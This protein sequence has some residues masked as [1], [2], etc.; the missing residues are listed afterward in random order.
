MAVSIPLS[1][2]WG[3]IALAA[4][5]LL[6]VVGAMVMWSSEIPGLI[7]YWVGRIGVGLS[8]LWIGAALL[9]PLVGAP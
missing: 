7:L 9:Y 1:L 3:L 2:I 6:W 8:Y 4:C 5:Y